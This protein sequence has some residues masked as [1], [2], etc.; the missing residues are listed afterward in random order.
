MTTAI[1][2][3]SHTKDAQRVKCEMTLLYCVPLTLLNVT[4][5]RIKSF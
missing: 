2:N 4:F 5:V 3:V 1:E